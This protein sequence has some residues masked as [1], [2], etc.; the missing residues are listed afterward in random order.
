MS[1]PEIY[2]EI[3]IGWLAKIY[4]GYGPDRWPE[5]LR[6]VTTW[7]YRHFESAASI[8]DVRYEFSDGTIDGW[9]RAD[10]EFVQNAKI[11]LNALYPIWNPLWW[12]FRA[13]AYAKIKE[14]QWALE[15]AGY[16]AYNEAHK[17][18]EAK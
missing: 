6:K 4:N 5:C 13:I 17:R 11:Q 8:H 10:D 15:L 18:R 9:I 3:D 1:A 7:F 2:W 14:A 12:P 16:T